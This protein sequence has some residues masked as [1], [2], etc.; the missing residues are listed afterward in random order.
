MAD[1]LALWDYRRRVA[2]IYHDVRHG[3]PG[4]ETWESWRASRDHLFSTHPETP[5]EETTGF[6]GITYFPYDPEWR[7]TATFTPLPRDS[8]SP[9]QSGVGAT[10]FTKLGRLQFEVGDSAFELDMLWLDSYGGGVFLPFRDKT[11]G[12]ATYGGGRYLLDSAKGADLGHVRDEVVLDFNFAYHPSC[13]HS[14]R[15]SCPLAPE[16]N[17]LDVAVRAGERLAGEPRSG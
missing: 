13:V 1:A 4:P 5:L 17:H 11:N 3:G 16:S 8:V 12:K 2:E 6:G 15:W 7:T 10:R 9:P 14:D